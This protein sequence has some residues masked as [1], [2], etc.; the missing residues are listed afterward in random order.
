MEIYLQALLGNNKQTD[1]DTASTLDRFR[2]H[3]GQWHL[4]WYLHNDNNKAP[5]CVGGEGMEGD[6]CLWYEAVM[7]SGDVYW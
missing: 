3:S 2:V 7:T 6:Q 1:K 4:R 5:L